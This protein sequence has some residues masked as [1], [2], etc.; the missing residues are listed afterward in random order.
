MY[1]AFLIFVYLYFSF[2]AIYLDEN[3]FKETKQFY[4]NME[5]PGKALSSLVPSVLS[6]NIFQH[7]SAISHL[8]LYWTTTSWVLDGMWLKSV[9][10]PGNRCEHCYPRGCRSRDQCSESH[11]ARPTGPGQSVNQTAAPGSVPNIFTCITLLTFISY[12]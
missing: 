3:W 5:F 11:W 10:W 9:M 2:A 8:L 1:E 12:C 4:L 7:R 6:W